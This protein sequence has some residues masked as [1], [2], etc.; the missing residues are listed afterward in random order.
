[1][2]SI[3]LL[4]VMCSH[5]KYLMGSLMRFFKGRI[6]QIKEDICPILTSHSKLSLRLIEYFITTY[7]RKNKTHYTKTNGEIFEVFNDYKCQLDSFKKKHFDP[8]KRTELIDF[9]YSQEV[10][11]NEFL[12]ADTMVVMDDNTI[13]YID[14]IKIGD[15]I[16]V[17]KQ[18]ASRVVTEIKQLNGEYNIGICVIS[19]RFET[20]VAQL[21]FFRWLLEN[22]VLDYIHY[23]YESIKKSNKEYSKK[24]KKKSNKIIVVHAKGFI[25]DEEIGIKFNILEKI[26]KELKNEKN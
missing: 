10:I 15:K 5:D 14:E 23:N 1:M 2:I 21:N 18:G 6:E 9:E 17:S 8:F 4:P 11:D 22:E 25:S 3:P 13:N 16:K 20:T 12:P 19:H 24:P 26:N 7:S